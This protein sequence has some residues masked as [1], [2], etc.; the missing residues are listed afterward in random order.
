[1]LLGTMEGLAIK[2]LVDIGSSN[3]FIHFGLVKFLN[4]P[5][6]MVQPLSMIMDDGSCITSGAIYTRVAWKVQD[7]QFHFGLN[8]MELGGWD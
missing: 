3:N 7:Y 5:D 8:V 6:Q 4:L 1:M 2:I